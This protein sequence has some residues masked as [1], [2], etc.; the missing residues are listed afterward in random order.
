MLREAGASDTVRKIREVAA[1]MRAEE[2]R[3]FAVRTATADRSQQLASVVTVAGS[4]LVIALAGISIFL[5]R[6]SSRARDEAEAQVARQ[7][8]QPRDHGR[9]AHRRSA[10]GQ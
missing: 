8:R 10:R 5:V 7:Q 3:L 9:R 4:G 2:D 1:A 6:R